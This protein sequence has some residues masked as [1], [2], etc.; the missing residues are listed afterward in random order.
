[1]LNTRWLTAFALQRSTE[2]LAQ[3]SASV[4]FPSRR[5]SSAMLLADTDIR[6]ALASLFPGNSGSAEAWRQPPISC[7]RAVAY[8]PRATCHPARIF[9]RAHEGF[10]ACVLSDRSN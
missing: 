2:I 6:L 7:S 4:A 8:S 5:S 3:G 9:S 1:M 10:D